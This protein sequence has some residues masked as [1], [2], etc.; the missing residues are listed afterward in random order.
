MAWE[1]VL[2][3]PPIR[4]PRESEFNQR[5]NENLSMKEYVELF[6]TVV[7]PV[8]EEGRNNY[9]VSIPLSELKMSE[10]KAEK[11]ARKLYKGMGY[12]MIF[13]HDGELYFKL[14]GEEK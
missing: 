4:N 7:D 9:A 8:I 5:E 14:K 3:M 6:E 12:S 10:K 2:K 13:T 1:D 11:I